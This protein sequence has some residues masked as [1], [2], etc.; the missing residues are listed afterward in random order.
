MRAVYPIFKNIDWKQK[1]QKIE[2]PYGEFVC[3]LLY[4]PEIK[5]TK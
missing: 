5:E 4:A 1:L 2:T 3:R